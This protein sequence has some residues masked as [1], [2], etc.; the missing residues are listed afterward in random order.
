[1]NEWYNYVL[2]SELTFFLYVHTVFIIIAVYMYVII[3]ADT[4][5]LIYNLYH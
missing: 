5:C 2:F 3:I 1:M 4:V